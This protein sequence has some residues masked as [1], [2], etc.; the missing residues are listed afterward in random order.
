[1]QN[2]HDI[3]ED[4]QSNRIISLELATFSYLLLLPIILALTDSRPKCQHHRTP[5]LQ[6]NATRLSKIKEGEKYFDHPKNLLKK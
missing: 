4:G 2:R 6:L 3:E 5:L 1:M